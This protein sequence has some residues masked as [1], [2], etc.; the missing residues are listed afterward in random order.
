MLVFPDKVSAQ[1]LADAN[2]NA[3]GLVRQQVLDIFRPF[4]NADLSAVQIVFQPYV[5]SLGIVAYSVEIKV[6]DRGVVVM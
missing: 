3:Y 1:I 2:P 6:E 4:H 5:H